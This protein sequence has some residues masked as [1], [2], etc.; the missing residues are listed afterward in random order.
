M[1]LFVS[2][3]AIADEGALDGKSYCRTVVYSEN[4]FHFPAGEYQHCV[5]FKDGLGTDNG[6]AFFESPPYTSAYEVKDGEVTVGVYSYTL[7]EDKETLT[8]EFSVVVPGTA[9]TLQ[10]PEADQKG[11]NCSDDPE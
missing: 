2:H 9:L 7:S 5:S 11:I 1:I 10:K 8:T 6:T 3:L 4:T